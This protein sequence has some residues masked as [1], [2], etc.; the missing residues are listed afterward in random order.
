M[1]SFQ[2]QCPKCN[3]VIDRTR[4]VDN[5]A[6]CAET[7]CDS[8]L[9]RC[10]HCSGVNLSYARYCRICGEEMTPFSE[11]LSRWGATTNNELGHLDVTGKKNHAVNGQLSRSAQLSYIGGQVW[12]IDGLLLPT[13]VDGMP[14]PFE[15]DPSPPGRLRLSY[16][17]EASAD[18]F[19][20][21]RDVTDSMGFQPG[22]CLWAKPV[23]VGHDLVLS[24]SRR[25]LFWPLSNLGRSQGQYQA[26]AEWIPPEER[27]VVG[28]PL[29]L[30]PDQ[31]VVATTDSSKAVV[32]HTLQLQGEGPRRL[33]QEKPNRQVA[34]GCDSC[35]VLLSYKLNSST[36]D[37]EVFLASTFQ[38]TSYTVNAG[39]LLPGTTVPLSNI[40][41]MGPVTSRF[42]MYFF[43]AIC[44]EKGRGEWAAVMGSV[45]SS[46][47]S[48]KVDVYPG[49]ND[50]FRPYWS[51]GPR[52]QQLFLVGDDDLKL[53]NKLQWN[54]PQSWGKTQQAV[55]SCQQGPLVAVVREYPTAI[56]IQIINFQHPTDPQA[57]LRNVRL[58]GGRP[59]SPDL[60]CFTPE[61]LYVVLDSSGHGE[62]NTLVETPL[63][64]SQ[65]GTNW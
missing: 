44:D 30:G 65:A 62:A 18:D 3:Q 31:L 52:G 5:I 37:Q 8:T 53:Y 6:C 49:S 40:R 58:T 15:E 43:H 7:G 1:S 25:L 32:L 64:F 50:L 9:V 61:K 20:R 21:F 26:P 16:F 17:G 60:I 36:Q 35:R 19:S 24:T 42:A 46:A 45:M 47:E 38:I 48:T 59:P 23:A 39:Q 41:P 28:E 11:F 4:F 13:P 56:D 14:D 29:P 12:L 33:P 51:V 54:A 22:E 55:A 57:N 2:D 10:S 27:R 34:P 63:A